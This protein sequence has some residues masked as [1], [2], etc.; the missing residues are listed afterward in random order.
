MI[1]IPSTVKKRTRKAQRYKTHIHGAAKMAFP[2]LLGDCAEQTVWPCAWRRLLGSEVPIW[3]EGMSPGPW[4]EEKTQASSP[5]G[6]EPTGAN[7]PGLLPT[8]GDQGEG[9]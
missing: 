3:D 6:L 8:I 9:A 5:Q 1:L 2:S 7:L 4:A